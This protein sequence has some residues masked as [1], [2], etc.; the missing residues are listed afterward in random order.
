MAMGYT[1]P[2]ALAQQ[3][4]HPTDDLGPFDH[5]GPT[6]LRPLTVGD[7]MDTAFEV[8]KL[9]PKAVLVASATLVVPLYLVLLILVTE[10]AFT[11]GFA[12]VISLPSGDISN[13]DIL[14][15]PLLLAGPL[16][17]ASA[18][19]VM[20]GRLVQLWYLG[21]DA[22]AGELLRYLFRRL[23]AVLTAFVLVHIAEVLGLFLGGVG[24]LFALAAFCMTSPVLGM[25]EHTTAWGAMRRSGRLAMMKPGKVTVV[26]LVGW[27]LS[28]VLTYSLGPLSF[29]AAA[30]GIAGR[31]M[32]AFSGIVVLTVSAPVQALI[33]VFLYLDVR[34][35]AEGLDLEL[36]T[37]Q[38][39]TSAST[40]TSGAG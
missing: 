23:P 7:I 10:P 12:G 5:R 1:L 8:V 11:G 28:L 38:A 13:R 32:W 26:L 40:S 37:A 36:K 4:A 27:V 34:I 17:I 33:M 29:G 18:M 9:R 15:I 30:G 14:S 35:R 22:T 16:F 39:F 31:A 19:G 6:P 20:M 3:N 24:A 25:E 2:A 21:Y